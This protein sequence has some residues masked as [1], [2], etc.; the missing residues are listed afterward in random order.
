MVD[1][2]TDEFDYEAMKYK[3]SDTVLKS[4]KNIFKRQI[5][6]KPYASI[7][8][9][10]G[11]E[12]KGAFHQ[13]LYDNSIYHKQ[14]MPYRHKQIANVENLNKQLGR[15]I[16]G[17]MQTISEEN[18]EIYSEWTD[19]LDR[20]RTELNRLRK[21]DVN[22]MKLKYQNYNNINEFFES[23]PK[24]KKGDMVYHKLE[25]PE[26]IFGNKFKDGKFRMGDRRFSNA[27]K[28]IQKVIVMNDKP[29][30][31]YILK[32]IKKTSYS[33]KELRKATNENETKYI[34]KH[35]VKKKK[36]NGIT[37]YLVWFKN[38]LKKNAIWTPEN[39]LIEDGVDPEKMLKNYLKKD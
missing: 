3:D 32:G 24:Y 4:M 14:S 29:F 20:L 21:K 8:T 36:I 37:H 18:N 31:R 7:S 6:K 15:L 17:Y 38:E 2:A 26:D 19:I 35:I 12:F 5:L 27:P 33:D 16:N 11:S 10:D 25:M 22:K 1:L 39:D 9:D 28:K 34:I 30:Y 13:Y 23:E